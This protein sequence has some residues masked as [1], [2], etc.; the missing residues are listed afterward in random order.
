MAMIGQHH[1]QPS[2]Y[3]AAAAALFFLAFT[4]AAPQLAAGDPLAP[5]CGS[6]GNYTTNSTYQNNIQRLASTLPKKTSSSPT[7]FA[8]GT[9]GALPDIVYALAFCRGDA[10][11]SACSGCVAAGFQDAQQLCA[12]NKDAAVFYDL[13]FL[14]YSNQDFVSSPV[15]DGRGNF[16][17]LSNTQNVSAPFKVFDAAVAVL[18]N[19]TADYAA[20]PN[21]SRRFGTGVQGFQSFD[22]ENPKIYGLAQCSP[23][24]APADCR[25]C[26]SGIIQ[27]GIKYEQYS[28][29]T[30]GPLL[31]LPEPGAPAPSPTPAVNATPPTAGGGGGGGGTTVNKTG[32]VL[33][34][35]LPIVAA[36]LA[37]LLICSCLWRRKRKTPLKAS[38]PD[39]TDPEDI[40]S[41]DS[42]IIDLSTLRAATENFDEANKLGKG[43]FGAVYKGILP[44]AQE[45]AVKR[46]S[47]SSRQGIGELKN[48]LVL[49]AKLQH[50]NLVR[51]IG[52]CL[53]DHEKLLVYEYMPNKSL[54]T[55]LFDHERC[56]ELDWGKRIKIVNGIARGLQYLHEDS[57]VK[58]IHRDLKASNV[59]LDN[60]FNPKIS[61]FGLARLFGSDQSQDVTNR[62]VGTYGYMAPEYAMRGH[63]SIK[64]DV[65]SFGVLILEIVTGRRNGGSYI[66]DESADL[67]SLMWEH[68]TM[69]TLVEI[70]DSS[71]SSLAP[72]DQMVKCIHIGLLCVQD[73]PAER[74]MMSMVNVMLSSSTV[75]LQAPSKPVFC[76]QKTGFNSEM[77]SGVYPG[78]SHSASRSPMSMNDVSITELEPSFTPAA[79]GC[80][81]A[82]PDQHDGSGAHCAR[83]VDTMAM[84]AHQPS[85]L[86]VAAFLFLAFFTLS[87]QLAAGD[88][89]GQLCGNSGNYTTNST[90]QKN[91]QR[92]AATLPKNTSSSQTLFAKDSVGTVPDIVYALALCRGDTNASTCS[93]CVATA[94]KDAQQL[95]ANNKDATIFYDPCLL[96]YSNL[97]FID[98]ATAGDASVLILYNSQN[99][100][101]PF[102]V[103]DNAVAT[104]VNATADYAA[105]N[106]S[107]R[108]GTGVEQFQT[109]DSQNPTIYGLAQCTPDMSPAE[110][111]SCLSNGPQVFQREAGCKDSGPAMQ[112]Q[113]PEPAVGVPAPAPAP[114]HKLGPP[115]VNGTPPTAGGGG[116]TRNRTGRVLAIALPIVAA[117]LAS[118]L[119]C[120]CVWRR[121][122]KTPGTSSLPDTTNPEDIQSIDSLIIDLS[123]LRAATE[124]FD[125][126]NKLG[127]GG[128]GAVYKGILLDHQEIA[129]KRLSQSSRQG[130][131]EL[132]NELVLV[133]K[134]QHKNLVR[135]IGVCLEDHEKLLVYEYMP[136]K[137]LDTVLF[138]HNRCSELDWGKRFKIVNGIARGLQYLHEDSQVK[139]IH[140]DLKASNVLLDYDFNPKIS[141]FGLARLFGSDQS[142]DVTNRVVGTYGYMAPEYAMRGHYS[143]KSD[144]FSFGVLILE[145]VTGR[146][147]GGSYS[148]DESA[149]LISMVWEHWTTGTLVEI[150]DPSLSS[151][152]PRDQMVKCIHIGLLCVQDDPAERPMMST[153]NVMLSSSTVTLQAPSKPVFCIQK[154][155]FNS[156]MD[157]GVYPGSSHSANRSP[158]SMNDVSIT[159]LE[160]RVMGLCTTPLTPV[161]WHTSRTS[162]QLALGFGGSG[163][164]TRMTSQPKLSLVTSRILRA[165]SNPSS[166]APASSAPA[167]AGVWR[168]RSTAWSCKYG[169]WNAGWS[170]ALPRRK[171]RHCAADGTVSTWQPSLSRSFRVTSRLM[172][173]LS[174]S[175]T[176]RPLKW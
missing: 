157:S 13:C 66:S 55:I 26:L 151:L 24:M 33:A 167:T 34:I 25:S 109:F 176:R 112:L 50:K 125:E 139:I 128:F 27:S 17:I 68:W 67:I 106:S 143:I 71:L 170:A 85:Y 147:N 61:D 90:Y 83:T 42:L 160:P 91:I 121:K 11:A 133:A 51:L 146:R 116:T 152:A 103:F 97:N 45:I 49:V 108:F 79:C 63:Y 73:D 8:S 77:D 93:D 149:D 57:Q 16:I 161:R 21:S 172:S 30:G 28:F 75:T 159:E 36:I 29:F 127:E 105:A 82:D 98:S 111:R 87:P 122:R 7:L 165:S 74:P 47:Q 35:A 119:I 86:A 142:Q 81:R 144:V 1:S 56:T 120:S 80:G 69:G 155:G 163:S 113:L 171:L 37:T 168:S 23:N 84:I 166:I 107:K 162:M 44:D 124:N 92:L 78:A 130:I 31:Q 32:R 104:L 88:P 59:L 94:F 4:L 96:R 39:T 64:S 15:S 135:L 132:K 58:I 173:S 22:A 154:T 5:L 76:I 115:A 72:R 156:E 123:T 9:I 38:L 118:L 134:L 46:L 99:V 18:L 114:T 169:N 60:D 158:M 53:E 40:E 65:F 102:K 145:I 164:A 136:N 131:E 95:C 43:G 89:L 174:A 41:I 100:T 48:E 117:I 129:V 140:R 19:A 150:M 70:M 101:V 10:N 3:L 110:C 148:S 137:S 12:Y 141:D 14:R 62:V 138:D 175:R 52:V 153:V 20:S 54:D 2:Y 6:S 126:A